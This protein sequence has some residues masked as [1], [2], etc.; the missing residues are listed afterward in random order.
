MADPFDSAWLK[1]AWAV[2]EAKALE[3]DIDAFT[4][5][6]RAEGLGRTRCDYQPKYHRFA[7][8]LDSLTI[9]EFPQR[10]GI[11]L[12]NIVH[13]YRSALDHVA[14][15][16]AEQGSTPPFTLKES[17][18][19]SILF[20][21]Q[22]SRVKFNDGIKRQLPGV[23]RA[24]I[25]KVRRYQPYKYGQIRKTAALTILE[26]LARFDKHRTIQPVAAYP[27]NGHL[28]VTYMRDCVVPRGTKNNPRKE[29]E[30]DA[31][32]AYVYVRKDG[33][34]PEMSVKADLDVKPV[35]D[36]G[37]WLNE[38]LYNTKGIIA[39]V[40]GQFAEPPTELLDALEGPA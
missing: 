24:E 29:L 13:N 4:K 21:I 38:W 31:E 14:W 9:A 7:V 25:A 26:R 16:L 36:K 30:V 32:F 37:F 23:R 5:H 8:V 11:R 3:A 18:Q 12:G 19:R 28:E 15:T 17:A 10:W 40:L 1:W 6:F 22:T 2:I 27:F 39:L 20:P 35:I 34:K 33:P